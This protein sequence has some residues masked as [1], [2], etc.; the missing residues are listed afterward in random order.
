MASKDNFKSLKMERREF[1]DKV[2]NFYN[3]EENTPYN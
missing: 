2:I 1:H 3:T